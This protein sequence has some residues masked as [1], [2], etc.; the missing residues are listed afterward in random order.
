[1]SSM[2]GVAAAMETVPTARFTTATVTAD[3]TMDMTTITAVNSEETA[4]AG[5]WIRERRLQHV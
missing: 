3:T 1:M 5:V 2:A 4:A